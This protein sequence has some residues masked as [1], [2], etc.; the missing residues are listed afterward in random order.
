MQDSKNAKKPVPAIF[1][2]RDGTLNVDTQY[3]IRFEDFKV[4]PGV[5]EALKDLQNKGY[6]LFVVSNQSGVARGYFTLDQVM[7]LNW[8]IKDYFANQGIHFADMVICPHLPEGKVAKFSKNCSCRKP[9][10]G[11]ILE[12]LERYP[13]DVKG[14][15]MVGDRLI[16]VISGQAAGLQGVRIGTRLSTDSID[17]TDDFREFATLLDFARSLGPVKSGVANPNAI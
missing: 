5:E 4:I 15:Y 17:T 14:S 11:M 6:Q 16:D 9:L 12:L 10:P 8:R 3:L 1:L 7:E 2:D 13:I